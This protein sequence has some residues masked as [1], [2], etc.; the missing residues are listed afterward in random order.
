MKEQ[1]ENR[2]LQLYPILNNFKN[3]IDTILFM[4][5]NNNY[6]ESNMLLFAEVKESLNNNIYLFSAAKTYNIMQELGKIDE[7]DLINNIKS[8]TIN[9]FNKI[10]VEVDLVDRISS[11]SNLLY[12]KD[13]ML[14]N[15]TQEDSKVREWHRKYNRVMLPSTDPF[16]TTTATRIYG[17]WNDRCRCIEV[18]DYSQEEL[19]ESRRIVQKNKN[20]KNLQKE[21]KDANKRNE[22]DVIINIKDKKVNCFYQNSLIDNMPPYL[23]RKYTK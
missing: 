16:W 22:N 15:I 19:A 8:F 17:S 21:I 13:K 12:K 20:D 7:A 6:K 3:D 23:R 11:Y 10:K 4:L 5:L 1:L 2:L 18:D 14:M 9:E